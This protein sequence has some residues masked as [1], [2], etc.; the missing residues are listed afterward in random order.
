[1]AT[2]RPTTPVLG[3]RIR[4]YWD[5]SG[6]FR[7]GDLSGPHEDRVEDRVDLTA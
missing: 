5:G 2:D 6:R 3:V 1:M 7:F 4:V